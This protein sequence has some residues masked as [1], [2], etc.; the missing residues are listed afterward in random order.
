MW[1]AAILVAMFF[2]FF[3]GGGEVSPLLFIFTFI[4]LPS[5]YKYLFK[6]I[7]GTIFLTCLRIYCTYFLCKKQLFICHSNL[8]RYNSNHWT[9]KTQTVQCYFRQLE[10]TRKIILNS[11][12]WSAWDKIL[13]VNTT[14]KQINVLLITSIM[15]TYFDTNKYHQQDTNF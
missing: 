3:G 2:F 7:K 11:Q 10:G 8:L 4:S 6:L 12:T 15:V 5:L 14:Y 1:V 9:L 13:T